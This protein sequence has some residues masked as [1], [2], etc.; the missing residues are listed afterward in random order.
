MFA[1]LCGVL[2]VGAAYILIRTLSRSISADSDGVTAQGGKRI[3]YADLKVLDLRK[4]ETKGLAYADYDGASG[5]GRLRIDG[6]TYGGFKKEHDQ[7]AEKLMQMI[8]SRFAGEIIEYTTVSAD[9]TEKSEAA[10]E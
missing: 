8:R 7:P 10:A 4:W 5:K 3:P 9:E 2:A 6:L 1:A